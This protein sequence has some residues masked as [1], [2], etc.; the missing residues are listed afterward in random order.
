MNVVRRLEA[1]VRRSLRRAGYADSGTRLVVAVSGG[2]DSMAL[3]HCLTRLREEL[4]LVLHVGHVD[5]DFR[6]EEAKEDARFVAAVARELDIPS[7]IGE[8]DPKAHQKRYKVSSFEEAAR[9]VRYDYL[10]LVAQQQQARAIALGHTADDQAETLLMHILRGTSLHGLRGMQEVIPWN[11]PRGDGKGTLFRPLL[12]VP[13]QDTLEY[14]HQLDIAFRQDT[15]N[16]SPDFTRSRLRHQLLPI[17]ETYNPRVRESLIRLG[18]S[19]AQAQDYLGQKID[20]IWTSVSKEVGN[21][22]VLDIP[23]LKSLHPIMQHLI[24]RHAYQKA[25]GDLRRLEETHIIQ[26]V[27]MISS[28]RGSRIDLPR[29]L[30]LYSSG[31][32]LVLG[33]SPEK[34]CPYPPLDGE[35][36][37]EVP[38]TTTIP[39][40]LVVAEVVP[41]PPSFVTSDPLVSFFDLDRI[42]E[43]FK[44]RTRRDGDRFQPLGMAQDKKLQDFY[45]D[46]KV[47]RGWRDRVPLLVSEVGILWVVG[48]RSSEW[49]KVRPDTQRV[50]KIQWRQ[51]QPGP[52]GR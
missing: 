5:H 12:E 9:E 40:W 31:Q 4:D 1:A 36:A 17:L 10:A 25:T 42:G 7:T 45:V 32:E 18:R 23:K 24:M 16:T 21:A 29:G 50:V 6:G 19:A 49:A 15:T 44:A 22:V 3:L 41:P 11:S 20:G 2:P 28:A 39:A 27:E 14:C 48:Y 37:L 26:M 47:P 46:Q 8:A 35:H 38:G 30:K 52:E 43:R 51:T 13:R 33:A 34:E